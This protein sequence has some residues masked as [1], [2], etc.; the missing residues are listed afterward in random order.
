MDD[1]KKDYPH[2]FI[3]SA[4][5]KGTPIE[6]L[7]DWLDERYSHVVD[8]IKVMKELELVREMVFRI[9][10]SPPT[11]MSLNWS[12]SIHV[13]CWGDINYDELKKLHL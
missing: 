6:A 7:R 3:S 9:Y 2:G 12:S 5:N 8:I 13:Y 1:L 11:N 4:S 10:Q